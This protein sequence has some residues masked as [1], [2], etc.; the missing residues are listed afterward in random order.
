MAR[1]PREGPLGPRRSTRAGRTG[2]ARAPREAA[3]SLQGGVQ[4][5]WAR[6][7]DGAKVHA[8]RLT[9]SARRARAPFT[10]LGCGDEL[11]PHL[12][13][14]RARHFAHRPGS[15]CPLTAPET[16]LHLDA[17]ERLLALCADAFAGRR[18]VSL[19]VRCPGCRRLAPRDLAALGDSAEEEGGVGSLR[20]D[21]LVRRGG[22][23]S[24]AIE[25]R[26]TH[27][28]APEKEAALAAAG[29]PAVE[30]DAREEW[31]REDGGGAAVACARCL[32][33]PP[34]AACLAQA[35][36]DQERA[37]GGEAAEIAE[38]EIYRARGLLLGRGEAGADQGQATAGPE[39][40]LSDAELQD[41][42]ACFRCPECGGKAIHFGS[43]IA[44]HACPGTADRPVAWRGYDGSLVLL[45][46]WSRDRG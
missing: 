23:P 29:V 6:D 26:V 13:R 39:A 43:R 21:V 28:V 16:A 12:G 18:K 8:A 34:C 44:R 30:I 33:F 38:L 17:K 1:H 2:R 11:V 7:R 25:V 32:G 42:R 4:L 27:A 36:A 31:E 35:R 40:P 24:L 5:A 10:C 15:R 37:K 20:A 9:A 46:W 3:A 14:V 19:L 22:A 45:S 41:L